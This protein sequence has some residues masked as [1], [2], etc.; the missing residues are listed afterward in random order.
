MKALS[1]DQLDRGLEERLESQRPRIHELRAWWAPDQIPQHIL[2]GSVLAESII[3][4]VRCESPVDLRASLQALEEMAS[5]GDQR[6]SEAA[7]VSVIER[8]RGEPGICAAVV[9]MLGPSSRQLLD[10]QMRWHQWRT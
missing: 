9:D 3:S 7:G 1:W 4:A 10:D 5:S 6:L 8:I 2:A